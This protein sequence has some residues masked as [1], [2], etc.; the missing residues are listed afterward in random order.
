MRLQTI[1]V[2]FG[3]TLAPLLAADSFRIVTWNL[4][5]YLDA[6]AGTRA[7]KSMESKAAIR[8][9]IR[10][11]KPDVL[12]LQE[13]GSTNAL[14]ELQRA[15]KNESI[16]FP[17]SDRLS[18]TVTNLHVGVH[19]C[20]P[21]LERRQHTNAPYLLFGR[22]FRVSRGFADVTIQ[23]SPRY[24]FTLLTAH[25]KSRRPSPE[26]DETAMREQEAL[27]LR[28]K[29][30]ALL[31]TNPDLNLAVLGDLN[32]LQDAKSTRAVI[33]K[34]RLGLIDT[35][36]AERNCSGQSIGGPRNVTWT[37]FYEKDDTY[38]RVDYLLLSRGM[39]RE[40]N[41]DETYVLAAADWG[42]ASDHRPVVATLWAEDR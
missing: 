33:G 12:A 15:L 39:A 24:M 18:S 14:A 22:R 40:W 7:A 16:A 42:A 13:I 25:L 19:C 1:L 29:I 3:F 28:E 41:P 8:E 35:R 11:L 21:L 2:F 20:I 37:Y 26:A 36:P 9:S 31:K 27:L 23:L 32:D 34:G 4:E 6:P 17:Y 30:D 5:N 38:Q 10:L